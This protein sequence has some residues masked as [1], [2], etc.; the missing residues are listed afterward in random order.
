MVQGYFQVMFN[1]ILA[2]ILDLTN[3]VKNVNLN[4]TTKSSNAG[5]NSGLL[6]SSEERVAHGV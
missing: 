6:C 5:A 3:I 2:I 1:E 4:V